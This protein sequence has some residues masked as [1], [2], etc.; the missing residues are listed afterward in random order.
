M[1]HHTAIVTVVWASL[2]MLVPIR[3]DEQQPGYRLIDIGTFGGP[4]SYV[5]PA[6]QIGSHNQLNDSRT[7]VGGGGTTIAMTTSSNPVVCGGLETRLTLVNHAFEWQN[8]NLVDLGSLAGSDGCSVA[9]SVNADGVTSGHS[10]S[11]TVD[12]VTG[13]NEVHAVRWK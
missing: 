12:P 10:E 3:L 1:K 8:G 13:F 6:G 9:A 5:L 11:G 2:V 7:L 4:V